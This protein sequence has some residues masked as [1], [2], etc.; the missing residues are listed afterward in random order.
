MIIEKLIEEL[1][2]I[3]YTKNDYEIEKHGLILK[4]K[5]WCRLNINAYAA[6][7][8]LGLILDEYSDYDEDHGFFYYY[9][10][11]PYSPKIW[12]I[13]AIIENLWL[14]FLMFFYIL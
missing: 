13:M 9:K 10:I 2:N 11:V 3:G 14:L 12:L 4:I 7:T 8:S 1:H 6:L 5:Y